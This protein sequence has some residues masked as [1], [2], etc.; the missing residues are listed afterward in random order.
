MIRDAIL[1][2]ANDQ[3][4]VVDLYERP[5]A[6]D[7]V[8]ICT[9]V[10][11]MTGTRPVWIDASASVFFFPFAIVRFLEIHSGSED[12]LGLAGAG[13]SA[14]APGEPA[15]PEAAAPEPEL[16]I[17]EDFLRRVREI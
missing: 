5:A 2:L 12:V 3:P 14:G 8:V 13:V 4:L 16:E 10:R 1:H 9:N 15:E 7:T 6:S 17:D 11:T